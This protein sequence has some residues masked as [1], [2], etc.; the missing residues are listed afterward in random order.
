[1]KK[2][3]LLMM[4]FV[5]C[6]AV[7]ACG[8]S[9]SDDTAAQETPAAQ[10]SAT[11]ATTEAEPNTSAKVDQ[12]YYQ[13][14]EDAQDLTEEEALEAASFI[15]TA[16]PDF[17][18]DNE[19]M[20]AIMYNGFLLEHWPGASEA[21]R[22]FG[23]DAVQAVKYVYRGEESVDDEATQLNLEQIEKDAIEI[24]YGD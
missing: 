18:T 1:M 13:A 10:S 11:E 6:F 24:V 20:E 19:T 21:Y 5:L 8:S 15:A 23:Q 2:T 14:K 3:A 7:T 9:S 16:Y 22:K 17:Y 12:I 4:S